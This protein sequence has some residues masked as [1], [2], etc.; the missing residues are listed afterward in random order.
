MLRK[1]LGLR[2]ICSSCITLSYIWCIFVWLKWVFPC[3]GFMVFLS[4]MVIKDK[5]SWVYGSSLFKPL[6]CVSCSLAFLTIMFSVIS[7]LELLPY[8]RSVLLVSTLHSFDR[9]LLFSFPQVPYRL[10]Q[11]EIVWISL[12]IELKKSVKVLSF[13]NLLKFFVHQFSLF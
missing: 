3:Y 2:K 12:Y 6:K 9:G 4:Q 11:D 5:S 7:G 8:F 1:T 13:I 10:Y